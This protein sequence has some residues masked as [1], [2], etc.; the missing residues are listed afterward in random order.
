MKPI[1][2]QYGL[3]F[4]TNHPVDIDGYEYKQAGKYHH[5]YFFTPD[6]NEWPEKVIESNHIVDGFSPN[7]NKELHAGHLKNLAIAAAINNIC[8]KKAVSMLGACQGINDGAMGKLESWYA[9][10]GYDPEIHLDTELSPP[11]QQLKNGEGDYAGCKV[12]NDVVIYKSDGKPTYAAHDLSFAEKV[13]P[14]IYLTGAEQKEHFNSLG[15][16]DKH[17]PIGLLLGED[18]KKMKSSL[19]KEGDEANMMSAEELF[20]LVKQALI[21]YAAE[22]GKEPP[23]EA[24]K[25]AW[26]ILAWN[27]NSAAKKNN[28]K[29]NLSNWINNKSPGMYIS[30]ARTRVRSALGKADVSDK[31]T[32]YNPTVMKLLAWSSYYNYYLNMAKKEI[33][34]YHM[35]KYAFELAKVLTDVYNCHKIVGGDPSIVTAI[36]IAWVKLDEAMHMLSM[37]PLEKI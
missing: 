25:L 7:L 35:A 34:P 14:T 6:N 5:N 9:L 21:D 3:G 18:G 2:E 37:Y 15:L 28:T 23:P 27:F 32:D 33:E 22:N 10:A 20:D 12:Y 8:C 4:A 1:P 29:F 19:K 17:H 16:G 36:V 26:S 13:G 24:D 30:Y 31:I 11:L